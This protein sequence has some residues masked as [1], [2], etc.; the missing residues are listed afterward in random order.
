M[1]ES[2]PA[3]WANH[4]LPQAAFLLQELAKRFHVSHD[5]NTALVAK[6]S[7]L[8]RSEMTKVLRTKNIGFPSRRGEQHHV[9]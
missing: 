5:A 3:L 4:P 7:C 9:V 8:G 1:L 2:S 6:S